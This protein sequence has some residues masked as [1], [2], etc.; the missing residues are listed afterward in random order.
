MSSC[1]RVGGLVAD[2]QRR[3]RLLA[4]LERAAGIG[5]RD[6]H[7]CDERRAPHPDPLLVRE[8]VLR[9]H[10]RSSHDVPADRRTALTLRAPT[11]L[12]ASFTADEHSRRQGRASAPRDLGQVTVV[13]QQQVHP[14][15][16]EVHGHRVSR[17]GG[18][19]PDG[20]ARQPGS[21]RP[22]GRGRQSARSTPARPGHS[23]TVA[24]PDRRAGTVRRGDGGG[25]G[26]KPYA[27]Q[28]VRC[29]RTRWPSGT[30]VAV[31]PSQEHQAHD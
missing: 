6:R 31:R 13:V 28:P 7:P 10:S 11:R 19:A 17:L 18:P 2:A 14:V 21:A 12:P 23:A 25:T 20:P 1:S 22:R 4:H 15:R 24:A 30:R 29:R 3:H 8:R 16:R 27:A 9:R 26:Q 5:Q